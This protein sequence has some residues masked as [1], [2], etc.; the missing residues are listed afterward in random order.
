MRRSKASTQGR[1]RLRLWGWLPLTLLY[2]LVLAAEILTLHDPQEQFRAFP[3][4][5]PTSIHWIDA[6]GSLCWPYVHPLEAVPGTF[7]QYQEDPSVILPLRF[8]GERLR[9]PKHCQA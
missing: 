7:D 8:W 1:R 4:A 6:E 9:D 2:L 3:Y 5:P